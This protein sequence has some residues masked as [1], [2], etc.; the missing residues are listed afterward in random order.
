MGL[1]IKK[2]MKI[3]LL[4]QQISFQ[5]TGREKVHEIVLRSN[6]SGH[7]ALDGRRG[8]RFLS[9]TIFFNQELANSFATDWRKED[10]EHARHR[11]LRG[12]VD[13]EGV[14]NPW[15]NDVVVR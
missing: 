10:E 7:K 6:E 12:R 9:V 15:A 14:H 1:T 3:T 13:A 2:K 11:Q 8:R 4:L 5:P